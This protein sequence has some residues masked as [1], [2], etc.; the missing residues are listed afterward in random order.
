MLFDNSACALWI[1]LAI[2]LTVAMLQV[3]HRP[4]RLTNVSL[5]RARF[6]VHKPKTPLQT[7][8]APGPLAAG[9]ETDVQVS[10]AAKE[11]GDF[12]AELHVSSELNVF[13]V[14]VS[15]KVVP[16]EVHI[17]SQ[18]SMFP[19]VGKQATSLNQLQ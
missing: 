4:I 13:A 19:P 6:T 15:A 17:E 7:S 12:H 3:L 9:M 11:V 1:S 10:F 14:T 2:F 8:Y 16:D 5:E 18:D